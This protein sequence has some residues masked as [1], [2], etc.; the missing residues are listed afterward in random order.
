MKKRKLIQEIIKP[1]TPCSSPR[2]YFEKVKELNLGVKL[3]YMPH[4]GKREME[5]RARQ[6]AR[7]KND[8]T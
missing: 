2:E 5:R 7:M 3:N 4:Q 1:K 6:L 8:R